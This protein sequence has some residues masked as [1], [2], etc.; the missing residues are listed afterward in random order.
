MCFNKQ[1]AAPVNKPNYG[2]GYASQSAFDISMKDKDG[3]ITDIDG[4]TKEQNDLA[5]GHKKGTT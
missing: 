1:P 3:N 5:A 2:V 4:R